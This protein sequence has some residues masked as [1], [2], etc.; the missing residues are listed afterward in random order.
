VTE[1]HG[2]LASIPLDHVSKIATAIAPEAGLHP[3]SARTALLAAV[4]AAQA[5]GEGIAAALPVAGGD[6]R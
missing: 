6:A 3:A 2:E 1:R 4:R 5:S